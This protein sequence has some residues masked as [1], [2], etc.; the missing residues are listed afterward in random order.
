MVQIVMIAK[1][2]IESDLRTF[3]DLTSSFRNHMNRNSIVGCVF[4][5]VI[6]SEFCRGQYKYHDFQIGPPTFKFMSMMSLVWL[7]QKISWMMQKFS[8]KF[9]FWSYLR[10]GHPKY[11]WTIT[12]I[13]GSKLFIG[14]DCQYKRDS[15]SKRGQFWAIVAGR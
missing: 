5:M 4:P 11:D 10:F 7:V 8:K 13:F 9:Q 12:K 1:K 14:S 2:N 15:K 6:S 3:L